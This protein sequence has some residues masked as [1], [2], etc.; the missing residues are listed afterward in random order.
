MKFFNF[1]TKIALVKGERFIRGLKE[2]QSHYMTVPQLSHLTKNK[3]TLS[4]ILQYVLLC[5][6]DVH[7]LTLK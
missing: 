2:N 5:L 3:K 1:S 4:F 6:W 7:Q